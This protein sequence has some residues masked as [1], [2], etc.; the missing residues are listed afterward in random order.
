[1]LTAAIA[2]GLKIALQSSVASGA[3]VKSSFSVK[4]GMGNGD[5]C[6]RHGETI[7]QQMPKKRVKNS[8]DQHG[9][10]LFALCAL[11]VGSPSSLIR[12]SIGTCSA[13]HSL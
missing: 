11:Q 10:C 8:G 12:N 6:N 4:R 9:L 13:V 5:F 2:I 3:K 7:A 1:M